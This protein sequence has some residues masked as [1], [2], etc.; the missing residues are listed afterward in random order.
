MF[1]KIFPVLA[2]AAVLVFSTPPAFSY[3]QSIVPCGNTNPATRMIDGL[4][5]EYTPCQFS[6]FI[7]I[8]RS[9]VNGSMLM[10]S[11][12]AA[13]AFMYAGFSYITAGGDTSKTQ[14]AKEIFKK[15]LMGYIIMLSAWLVVK[16][17][18]LALLRQPVSPEDRG[19]VRSFLSSGGSGGGG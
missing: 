1:R 12:Y 8:I 14:H 5:P 13:V 4:K 9:L 11:V 19:A 6:N 15:V 17:I 2:L 16:A 10:V 3:G 7:D 18:E